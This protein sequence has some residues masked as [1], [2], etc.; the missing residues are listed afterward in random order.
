MAWTPIFA[1]IPAGHIKLWMSPLPKASGGFNHASAASMGIVFLLLTMAKSTVGA[2]SPPLLPLLFSPR[3]DLAGSEQRRD[4]REKAHAFTST[5]HTYKEEKKN[6]I[7]QTCTHAHM[8]THA[9]LHTDTY[10][11]TSSHS[12]R[13]NNGNVWKERKWWKVWLLEGKHLQ[14]KSWSSNGRQRIKPSHWILSWPFKKRIKYNKT[15][16][17]QLPQTLGTTFLS[18]SWILWNLCDHCNQN[19]QFWGVF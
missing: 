18:P 4:A 19:L 14:F 3:S 12:K 8:H 2:L 1:P 10:I 16:L 5:S 9:C 13:D 15:T 7:A 17:H 11:H 6:Q